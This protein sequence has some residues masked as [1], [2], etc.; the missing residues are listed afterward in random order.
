MN[1]LEK[2]ENILRSSNR[3]F[4]IMQESYGDN[5]EIKMIYKCG[6]DNLLSTFSAI[7]D[8]FLD[9]YTPYMGDSPERILKYVL[10]DAIKRNKARRNNISPAKE[11]KE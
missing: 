3:N 7:A 9:R 1:A 2:A 6:Y 4:I 10:E 8:Y 11:E 5:G